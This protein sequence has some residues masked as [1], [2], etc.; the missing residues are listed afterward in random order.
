AQDATRFFRSALATF[1][2]VGSR[3]DDIDI[4]GRLLASGPF[5]FPV[6]RVVADGCALVGDAAGYFDPF[7]GQGIYQAIASAELLAQ[8]AAAALRAGDVSAARLEAYARRRR[9]LL[10]GARTVQRAIDE[11]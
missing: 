3:L 2:D 6:R 4:H 10:R 8:E 5:D 9:A 7:T 11:V 1:A